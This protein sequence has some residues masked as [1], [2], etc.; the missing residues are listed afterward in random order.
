MRKNLCNTCNENKKFLFALLHMYFLLL[1]I[2][3]LDAL[4]KNVSS[5]YLCIFEESGRTTGGG[6]CA[7]AA[8][9]MVEEN[10]GM[11]YLRKALD[12]GPMFT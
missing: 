5:C 11:S 12:P 1:L 6:R 10:S 7:V 8:V 4:I 2:L 3:C 9:A